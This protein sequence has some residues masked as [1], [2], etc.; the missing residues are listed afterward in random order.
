MKIPRW[1]IALTGAAL[2]V[3]TVAGIG[4]AQAAAPSAIDPDLA[5]LTAA[6]A[7]DPAAGVASRADLRL[8]PYRNVVHGTVTFNRPDDGL[9]TVQVDGG[10]ITTV[11]ADSMTIAEVGGA[12][13]TVAIDDQTRVRVDRKR[14]TAAALKSGQTVRILSRVGTGN[15]ATAKLVIATAGG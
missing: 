13:V 14:A 2:T 12:S 1:R 10:T 5:G 3:L 4:L 9:V 11:D 8:R 7:A 6:V 15:A